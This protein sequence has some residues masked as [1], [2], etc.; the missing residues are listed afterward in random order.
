MGEKLGAV[1]LPNMPTGNAR[2]FLN[3]RTWLFGSQSSGRQHEL[4]K[5]FV[6]FS[7]NIVQQRNMA[8][9]LG[10]AVPVNPGISLPLKTNKTLQLV[11]LAAERG[12]LLSLDQIDWLYRT[13]PI[14][15]PH[16]DLVISGEQ[17]PETIAPRLNQVLKYGAKK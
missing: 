5:K 6:L 9:K 8:L 12:K 17:S 3:A 4:A 16:L 13:D 14:L 2:P 1:M 7:V 15:M 11:N 10:T